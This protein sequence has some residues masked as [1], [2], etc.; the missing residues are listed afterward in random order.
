MALCDDDIAFAAL[1]GDVSP[2]RDPH[3]GR[4]NGAGLPESMDKVD[5]LTGKFTGAAAAP[6][7]GDGWCKGCINALLVLGSMNKK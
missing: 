6:V 1:L 2:E 5:P 4:P 3:I 7:L